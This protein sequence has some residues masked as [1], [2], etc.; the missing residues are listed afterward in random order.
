MHRREADAASLEEQ[1]AEK[2]GTVCSFSSRLGSLRGAVTEMSSKEQNRLRGA[3]RRGAWRGIP[4]RRRW[5]CRSG[6]GPLSGTCL[7]LPKQSSGTLNLYCDERR[8]IRW[9]IVWARGKSC[10]LRLY[11]I[12]SPVLS[13]NIGRVDSLYCYDNW[14]IEEMSV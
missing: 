1:A 4:R 8:D 12:V 3:E 9:N 14:S 5:C 7:S 13:F 10:G 6:R 11:F 2:Q